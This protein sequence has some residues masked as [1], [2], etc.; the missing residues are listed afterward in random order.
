MATTRLRG[1]EQW[2]DQGIGGQIMSDVRGLGEA[3][4][5]MVVA[6]VRMRWWGLVTIIYSPY[7]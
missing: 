5:W 7:S 2:G 1:R 6:A 3:Y 4:E